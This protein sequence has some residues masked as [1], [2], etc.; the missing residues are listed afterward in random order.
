MP[1]LSQRAFASNVE[2]IKPK[3][4]VYQIS[5]LPIFGELVAIAPIVVQRMTSII[6]PD[7]EPT[8]GI[9]VG[10]GPLVNPELIRCFPIGTVVKFVTIPIAGILDGL[11]PFYGDV[12][13]VLM[14]Y[15]NVL[16]AVPEAAKVSVGP[17]AAC[18]D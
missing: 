14:R 4:G 8:I 7:A 1:D 10:M 12:R 9:I 16:A 11:Y 3:D 5:P 13:I 18:H 2:Y 6:V 17:G 15:A